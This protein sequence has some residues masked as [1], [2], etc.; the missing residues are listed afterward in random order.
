MKRSQKN[1]AGKFAFSM[2]QGG[3]DDLVWPVALRGVKNSEQQELVRSRRDIFIDE[4]GKIE[5]VKILGLTAL[6]TLKGGFFSPGMENTYPEV[7]DLEFLQAIIL[8]A[9]GEEKKELLDNSKVS[10]IWKDLKE[11]CYVASHEVSNLNQTKLEKLSQSTSAYYRNPYGD[12]FFDNMIIAITKEYD[13]RYVRNGSIE[14]IGLCLVAMRGE[15]ISRIKDYIESLGMIF[16]GIKGQK[17]SA[18]SKI[19]CGKYNFN[20]EGVSDS[21][22]EQGLHNAAEDYASKFLFLLD[23]DWIKQQEAKGLPMK[24]VLCSLSLEKNDSW[25]DLLVITKSNPMWSKP[26]FSI[27]GSFYLFSPLTL[28][29]FPFS[30]LLVFLKDKTRLEKI[31][32]WFVESEAKNLLKKSFP[33]ATIIHG[34]KWMKNESQQMETDLL[35]LLSGHL[36]IFEAKGA[37]LPDRARQGSPEAL[38]H[39]LRRVWGKSIE[40]GNSLAERLKYNQKP[41]NIFDSSGVNLVTIDPEKLLSIARYGISVEQIGLF[42]NSPKQL[43]S[44]GVLDADVA[45]APCIILS[46]LKI[47]LEALQTEEQ[48][49]HYLARRTELCQSIDFLGDELDLFVVYLQCGFD[50]LVGLGGDLMLLGASFSLR[51]Y[52]NKKG[53]VDLPKDS[54]LRNSYFFSNLLERLKYRKSDAFLK[55]ALILFDFPLQS[56]IEFEENMKLTFRRSGLGSTLPVVASKM[57]S[58][59]S[60]LIVCGVMVDNELNFKDIREQAHSIFMSNCSK[61]LQNEGFVFVKVLKSKRVYDA[62]Y[63]FCIN[64]SSVA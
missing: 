53:L 8:S 64:A 31:R 41:L 63:Y 61:F 13:A 16:N 25:N 33:S 29:S 39:F 52:R 60:N 24:E 54:S 45:P 20:Y 22:L 34:G 40:Q 56:Q 3:D 12:N 1:N 26:V 4:V 58:K 55:V 46:E 2:P 32:G 7:N 17:I 48:K 37:L 47:I 21:D 49:L 6:Y 62:L 5:P 42:M 10:G 43:K 35:V 59:K 44:E 57:E 30:A 15:I 28:A 51:E 50:G 19:T 23:D 27:G 36:I 11:Q 9:N 38:K 18:F 14:K